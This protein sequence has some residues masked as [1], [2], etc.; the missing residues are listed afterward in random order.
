MSGGG[1]GRV[2]RKRKENTSKILRVWGDYRWGHWSLHIH[3]GASLLVNQYRCTSQLIECRVGN[4]WLSTKEHTIETYVNVT[5]Q[6]IT[7][8]KIH[9][10]PIAMVLWIKARDFHY[11]GTE[12]LASSWG[13][14]RCLLSWVVNPISPTRFMTQSGIILC[15]V[16]AFKGRKISYVYTTS[17][18]IRS[19][20]SGKIS[21]GQ[22]VTENC[23]GILP[24]QPHM[25]REHTEV[26][27]SPPKLRDSTQM[28]P[29]T[30]KPPL[31]KRLHLSGQR[32]LITGEIRQ[33]KTLSSNF[34]TGQVSP[35]AKDK[36]LYFLNPCDKRSWKERERRLNSWKNLHN[37]V[38]VHVGSNCLGEFPQGLC[39]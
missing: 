19:N 2:G 16:Q 28:L 17:S 25:L 7:K 12:I 3:I 38:E 23:S 35:E 21:P 31:S 18:F 20:N 10:Q 14:Q 26:N 13:P 5:C 22:R 8:R 15:T 24:F 36:V 33:G 11:L 37:M 30:I 6:K 29:A 4:T 27:V 34:S 39:C 1:Q 32:S 9:C